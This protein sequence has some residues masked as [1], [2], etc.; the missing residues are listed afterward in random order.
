VHSLTSG[1]YSH[2]DFIS[3]R[4]AQEIGLP[5]DDPDPHIESDLRTYYNLVATDLE[6]LKKF[7]PNALLQQAAA[8]ATP[9][10]RSRDNNSNRNNSRRRNRRNLF[11]R[12]R[13]CLPDSRQSFSSR[14]CP[15]RWSVHTS[16]LRQQPTR[17]SLAERSRCSPPDPHADDAAGN[18]T[19][20]DTRAD[21]EHHVGSVGAS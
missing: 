18:A 13:Q 9:G 11:N 21:A 2:I 16:R 8:P 4:E 17:T 7:D 15:S 20:R 19:G 1:L 5:V 3:R 10:C 12:E 6:L 14:L